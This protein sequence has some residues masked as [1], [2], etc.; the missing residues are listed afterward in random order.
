MTIPL[1][2]GFL[3]HRNL[4]IQGSFGIHT[5][6]NILSQMLNQPVLNIQCQYREDIKTAIQML[7]QWTLYKRT[8][9]DSLSGQQLAGQ[10]IAGLSGLANDWWRWLQQE[11]RNEMLSAEDADQQILKALGK[12]FYGSEERE[13]S[14]HL[15]S[16]FMSARLCD[17]AQSEQYFCHMQQLLISFGKL[18]DPSYFKNYLR[19]F[20]GHV[21]DAVEQYMKNKKIH[22]R[23]LSLAQLHNYILE[24][25]QEH[26][27]EKTGQQ[28]FQAPPEY[29]F[30]FI[31]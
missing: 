8:Q 10:I 31:L 15:A 27:L 18:G 14:E 7:G 12:E 21:P 6:N 26:C 25:W 19:S 16:L 20:P 11:A 4:Q 13:D 28:R 24:T 23:G 3:K 1:T 2:S 29:V 22:Y 30:L 17:L 9:N 5:M